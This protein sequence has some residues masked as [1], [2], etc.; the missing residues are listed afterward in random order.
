MKKNELKSDRLDK[1]VEV[2]CVEC[3]RMLKFI[4]KDETV[5]D[6]VGIIA[7]NIPGAVCQ[8]CINAVLDMVADPPGLVCIKSLTPVI[9]QEFLSNFKFILPLSEVVKFFGSLFPENQFIMH[10]NDD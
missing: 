6:G 7:I 3:G 4:I 2:P 1:N 9:A 5:V 8:E 10:W